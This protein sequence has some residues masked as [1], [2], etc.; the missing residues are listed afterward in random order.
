MDSLGQGRTESPVRFLAHFTSLEAG[1]AL[2][3]G[4]G[5]GDDAVLLAGL[6]WKVTAFDL[7]PSAV[8]WAAEKHEEVLKLASGTVDWQVADI[9]N[10]PRVHSTLCWKYT[11][12]RQFLNQS[13]L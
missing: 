5:L 1:R 12:F 13:A 8:K 11:S 4:C 6:G 3:V 10:T 2:V 7:S 9:T